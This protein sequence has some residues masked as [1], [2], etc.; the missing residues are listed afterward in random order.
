MSNLTIEVDEKKLVDLVL[1]YLRETLGQVDLKAE[2]VKI[3][4]M[5]KNNYRVKEWEKGAFRARVEKI[6]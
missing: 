1:T 3:E 5:T 6:L 2:D 4:V